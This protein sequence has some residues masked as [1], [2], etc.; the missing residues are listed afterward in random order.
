MAAKRILKE[1]KDL[2]KGPPDFCSLA[3]DNEDMFI[4]RATMPGPRDSPYEGGKFELIIHFPPDYPY[5]PPKVAFRNKIFHPNINRNGSIGIDI[6]KDKWSPA[7]TISKVLLSIYSILGA[8]MLNDPLE[9]NIANMYKTDRSQYETVA[10]NWTQKYA[11]GPA[12]ETI[13]KELKGLERCPPS[14]GSAGPVDG[15]MFH[16]HAAILDLRNSPYDGGLFK[17]DIQ[18]PLQYPLE[19]PKVV[20][21]TKI[22]HPNIDTNGSIG[23]DILKDRWS[24]NLTIS[25]VLHSIC[26]LLKNPNPDAPLVSETANMYKTDR[27]KYDT[28]AR[29]W[30]QK[31]AMG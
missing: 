27:S 9:E 18:F 16:W 25:Q 7:L 31:Y 12:Y 21:R 11:M 20:F 29:S 3:P 30:T 2:Q 28:T 5:K 10:R 24:A 19:P 23:L 17:V 8:P 13:S 26:S 14:Y 4:W 22:F 15:D 6:L 1:F